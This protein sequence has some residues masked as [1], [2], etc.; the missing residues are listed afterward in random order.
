MAERVLRGVA[1]AAGLALGPVWVHQGDAPAPAASSAAG[2]PGAERRRFQEAVAAVDRDL[3]RL[4]AGADPQAR[5]I[6][7]AHRLMLADPELHNL[8]EA[9][10]ARGL[11]AEAAVQEATEQLAALLAGLD[12]PY[13]RERA[14]DVRDVGR[15]L[16]AALAGRAV[17]L[18]LE[19]PAVVVARDLAPTDTIGVDRRL[20]LGIVTEQGGPTSHTAILARSWGIPAVVG[21]PGVLEQ[22]QDGMTVAV[23]GDAGAVVLEPAPETVQRLEERLRAQAEAR[24]R[25]QA[26]AG[27]PAETPDGRRVELAG[28]AKVPGDVAAAVER[29]AEAIGLLRS[30]FLFMGRSA[31][32]DE[33]EQYQAYAEALRLAGGRRVIIRTLDIGGDKGVPY[34]GLPRE[35]NPFLGV[36]ALRLCFRRPDLFQTQLRALLR[37][38][39]H[40]RLAVM[41]PM[42]STLDDLRQARAALEEARAALAAA[43]IPHALAP[44]VGIM[45]EVPSAALIAHHLAREVDFFSIGTNDLVQ[46]TLAVDRG[47]PELTGLYQPSHP[48]V[49]RLIDEV[50]RAAHGAGKW[51][52]V[53]GEMAGDPLGALLLL[54][55]GVDEL[56]MSPPALPAV[57][58]LVRAVPF[59]E[60]EA[61]ARQALA[62][63]TAAEVEA[64]VRP[65]LERVAAG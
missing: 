18:R 29:G 10:I 2:D 46:Y 23:D 4:Q 8:V 14:A 16:V 43:G 19:A 50:V 31:P 26:E 30:E 12:D 62:C 37:A 36:R 28:N 49:L 35:E 32:P 21:V 3:E 11:G 60:A 65:V 53:C 45:I 51:V 17:G 15:R 48:A 61:L 64:L 63:S 34:L 25:E 33:E 52:G 13:L 57:R 38:G 24:A 55:L 1:A 7:G 20:L 22:V 5:E 27:L 54:G 56:S 59:R 40:G 58:R 41:F 39:V 9:G 47:H 42:V 6:L 44:E